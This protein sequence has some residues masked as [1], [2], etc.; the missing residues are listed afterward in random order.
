MKKEILI[1]GGCGFIGTPLVEHFLN[2]DYK[3][4]VVDTQWFG[5]YLPKNDKNLTVFK[6][7]IRDISEN[8]FR[9]KDTVIHLANICNDPSVD[10]NPT[11]SWEVNVLA[12]RRICELSVKNNIK[13]YYCEFWKCIRH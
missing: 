2:E 1:L 8:H 6:E 10:L 5:N 3:V 4:T 7:D 13:K 11:L 12:S 9:N